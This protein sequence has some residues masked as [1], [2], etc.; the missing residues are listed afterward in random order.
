MPNEAAS[1]PERWL[2]LGKVAKG[3]Q[4]GP[5]QVTRRDADGLS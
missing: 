2:L 5:L 3:A 4:L 1:A